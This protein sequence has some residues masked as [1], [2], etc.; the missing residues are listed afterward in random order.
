M[1]W[2]LLL[3]LLSMTIPVLAGTNLYIAPNGNDS[4][5]GRSRIPNKKNTD[6]PFATLEGA[7]NAIRALKQKNTLSGNV[8]IW[9]RGGDYY[10]DKPFE[11]T[12]ADSGTINTPIL[13]RAYKGETVRLIGGKPLPTWQPVSDTSIIERLDANTRP[14][15]RQVDLKAL[16]IMDYGALTRRGFVG[17][18]TLPPWNCSL[19]TDQ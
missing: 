10:R 17:G 8:T 3:A 15:V 12:E 6:G 4:W 14:H 1:K 11:L 9:I 19:M 2:L 16:G 7:R 5:S 18:N 13:Y